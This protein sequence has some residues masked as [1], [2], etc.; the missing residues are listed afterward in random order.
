MNTD[1]LTLYSDKRGDLVL[2]D[3]T[4]LPFT[5]KRIF[6]VTNVPEQMVR[7]QHGHY[8]CRQYY[9]CIKGIIE[10]TIYDGKEQQ[11]IMLNPGQ[12]IFIDNMIWSSE[13]FC[14]GNDVLL[15]LCSHEYDKNDY[16]T[17]LP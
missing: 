4:K 9:I 5:P 14:T 13:K 6:Y 8:K 12:G 11:S 10:V 2:I 7:G 15:V 3:Y 16:F 1:K 17:E